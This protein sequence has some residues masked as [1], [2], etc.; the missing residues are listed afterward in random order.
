M[1]TYDSQTM[2][3]FLEQLRT[4]A[5][6]KKATPAFIDKIDE[7]TDDYNGT[8][9]VRIEAAEQR[10]REDADREYEVRIEELKKQLAAAT[11]H[12]MPWES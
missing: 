2:T 6:D 4:W 7:L 5:I 9:E 11:R 8:S 3:E 12:K 1:R 10:T